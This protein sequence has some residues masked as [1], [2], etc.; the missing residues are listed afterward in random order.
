MHL[1]L[2]IIVSHDDKSKNKK[3]DKNYRS[4]TASP[5]KAR[6][7]STYTKPRSKS[8]TEVYV[9]KVEAVTENVKNVKHATSVTS[10]HKSV[11]Y[12]NV[13]KPYGPNQVWVPK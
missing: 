5:P 11:K 7:E 8:A 9:R 12:A 1:L 13:S 6:K 4:K 10:V 2:L 3:H